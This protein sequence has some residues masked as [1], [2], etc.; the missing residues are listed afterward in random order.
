MRCGY[1]WI[2]LA[3]TD[4]TKYCLSFCLHALNSAPAHG[5]EKRRAGSPIATFHLHSSP[6]ITTIVCSVTMSLWPC[7]TMSQL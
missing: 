1:T 6:N 7:A 2:C 5:L 3:K 4:A